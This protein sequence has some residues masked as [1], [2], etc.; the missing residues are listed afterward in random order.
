[1]RTLVLLLPVAASLASANAS[2]T[3]RYPITGPMVANFLQAN[4]V[5]VTSAQVR[6]PMELTAATPDP[7]LEIVGT[8]T[9]RD[10]ELRLELRCQRAG[11][12]LAFSALVYVGDE[13]AIPVA[14]KPE[15]SS[16]KL[17]SIR[18]LS[19]ATGPAVLRSN[20]PGLRVGSQ[21]V[22]L[23]EDGQMQIHLPVVAMDSGS[24]GGRVRV[25]TL[26]RKKVFQAVVV[27]AGVVRGVIE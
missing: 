5:N 15:H 7:Q 10:G 9:G 26:N 16:D 18:S 14:K 4:G 6:L 11:E 20:S 2:G 21:V 13:K 8:Q 12:C 1:M 24:S 22:L 3:V 27:D 25:C 17:A 23:I 19:G